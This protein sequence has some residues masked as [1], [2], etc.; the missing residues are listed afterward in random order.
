MPRVVGLS[1]AQV[2]AAMKSAQL[3]FSTRGPGSSTREWTTVVAQSPRPG[4]LVA[5]HAHATLTVSRATPHGPRRVPRL[6]GL[7]RA[8]TFAVMRRAQLY[9]STRG[10]GSTSGTWRVVL[11]Q[12]PAPGT[13]VAWHA[14]VR[15]VVSTKRPQSRPTRPTTTTTVRRATTTTVKRSTTTTSTAT[16]TTTT[17]VPVATTTYPGQTTTSVPPTTTSSTTTT[18][19]VTTTTVKRNP[20]RY[21]IGVATWYSYIPG[22]CA[23][24]YLPFGTRIRVRDLATGHSITC[25]V[26]DREAAHGNRV[27]DLNEAQF[28][29]LAPLRVGVIAVRVTW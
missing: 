5:W 7:S 9:F 23:T 13:R 24:W 16:T 11:R 6:S 28:A 22:H 18:V 8:R 15:L 14:T 27:V 2:Y 21:R 1:R 3:Y 12:S 19:R 20:G 10:P 17:T 4:T 29:Q 26:T 25:I